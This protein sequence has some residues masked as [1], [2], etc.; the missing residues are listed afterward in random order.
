MQILQRLV[1]KGLLKS[2]DV[3]RLAEAHAASPGANRPMHEFLIEKGVVK[4]E[5][6]LVT[7]AEEFGMDLVDLAKVT[8]PALLVRGRSMQASKLAWMRRS[9]GVARQTSTPERMAVSAKYARCPVPTNTE[10]P[11]AARDSV[12]SAVRSA[13]PIAMERPTMVAR[14]R[15]QAI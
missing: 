6:V 3:S 12:S 8:V 4:E 14:P 10:P 2:D 1:I 15:P 11:T 7:L 9:T 5:D 13:T